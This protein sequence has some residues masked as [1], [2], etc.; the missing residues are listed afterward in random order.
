MLIKVT[1]TGNALKMVENMQKV[2]FLCCLFAVAGS[3]LLSVWSG[4]C[5]LLHCESILG[6]KPCTEPMLYETFCAEISCTLHA[7]QSF[8]K[9]LSTH[10]QLGV[11]VSKREL[12]KHS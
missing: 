4:W 7:F 6:L 11:K 2:S 10:W 3:C 8:V 5:C 1:V 9:S 12:N